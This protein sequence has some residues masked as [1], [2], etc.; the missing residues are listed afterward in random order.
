MKSGNFAK[1]DDA[2]DWKV[3]RSVKHFGAHPT[4]SKAP[5]LDAN[6]ARKVQQLVGK[7]AVGAPLDA[8]GCRDCC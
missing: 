2:M 6:N 7:A 3:Q 8:R 5:L 1:V 4:A